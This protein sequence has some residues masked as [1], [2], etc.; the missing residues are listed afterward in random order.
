MEATT[1]TISIRD[2]YNPIKKH[3]YIF[4]IKNDYIFIW[5]RQHINDVWIKVKGDHSMGDLQYSNYQLSTH[6]INGYKEYFVKA[7]KKFATLQN[8]KD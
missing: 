2:K 8:K 4:Q 1:K 7:Q 6:S 3:V 5:Y